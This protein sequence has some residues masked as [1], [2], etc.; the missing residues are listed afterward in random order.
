MSFMLSACSPLAIPEMGSISG[1][2]ATIPSADD[3]NPIHRLSFGWCRL[4]IAEHLKVQNNCADSGQILRCVGAIDTARCRWPTEIAAAFWSRVLMLRRGRG[5]RQSATCYRFDL[6]TLELHE[7]IRAAKRPRLDGSGLCAAL[8]A[9]FSDDRRFFVLVLVL[10]V[11]FVFFVLV[12][13]VRVSRWRRIADEV[14]VDQPSGN[15]LGDARSHVGSY[16]M[17]RHLRTDV[18]PYRQAG[19]RVWD[20]ENAKRRQC[21]ELLATGCL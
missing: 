6:R 5:E 9:G 19:S 14:P 10:F 11:L 2:P 3:R 17:S 4:G 16:W 20:W 15:V 12:T 7:T 8:F 13:V 1:T 21:A 18:T